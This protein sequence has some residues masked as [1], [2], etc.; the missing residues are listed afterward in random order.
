MAEPIVYIDRSRIRPGRISELSLT[1]QTSF[2]LLPTVH[3]HC[4]LARGFFVGSEAPPGKAAL[5]AGR[6]TTRARTVSPSLIRRRGTRS[7]SAAR[8]A[9][10]RNGAMPSV[11]GEFIAGPDAGELAAVPSAG[12]PPDI[13]R[14]RSVPGRY[15]QALSRSMKPQ[16]MPTI[17]LLKKASTMR[18]LVRTLANESRLTSSNASRE[19]T[20]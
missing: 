15:G 10:I 2:R 3:G 16:P 5:S 20:W 4:W 1:C 11:I 8:F 7:Q 12:F 13:P 9:R 19:G 6:I 17:K 14:F 18:S